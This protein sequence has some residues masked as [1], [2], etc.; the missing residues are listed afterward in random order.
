MVL[1]VFLGDFLAVLGVFI[2]QLVV[3]ILM[4]VQ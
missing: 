4:V 2:F 3:F 1:S